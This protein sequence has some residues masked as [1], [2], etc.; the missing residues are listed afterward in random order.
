MVE[1]KT[2]LNEA[3]FHMKNFI[4][5][6]I[7]IKTKFWSI[8]IIDSF[9]QVFTFFP[10]LMENFRLFK[11]GIFTWSWSLNVKESLA[12]SRRKIRSLKPQL[13]SNP[14]PLSSQS[15]TEASL[16]KWL[17]VRLWTKWL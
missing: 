4:S 3:Y 14:E 16:A 13:D 6:L 12:R 8:Q 9:Y 10:F 15:N 5:R 1:F 11:P 2:N 7:T 17:S